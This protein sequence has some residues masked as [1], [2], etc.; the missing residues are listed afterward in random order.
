MA[1][2]AWINDGKA[3]YL[4]DEERR[5]VQRVG[6]SQGSADGLANG[7]CFDKQKVV[8][9]ALAEVGYREKATDAM[10]D[11]KFANAGPGNHTKYGR[12]HGQDRPVHH[13]LR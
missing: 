12:R 3:D 4:H 8:D 6:F 1:S 13:G 10:L 9:I 11:E 2:G 5:D 7:M